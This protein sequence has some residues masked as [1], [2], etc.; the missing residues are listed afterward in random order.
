MTGWDGAAYTLVTTGDLQ[1]AWTFEGSCN[2]FEQDATCYA[3]DGD[4]DDITALAQPAPAAVTAAGSQATQI[5]PCMFG[6]VQVTF[7]PTSGSGDIAVYR[8]AK[9]NS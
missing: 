7:T 1:G 3:N 5:A 8:T 2:H 9:G 4:F 6:S